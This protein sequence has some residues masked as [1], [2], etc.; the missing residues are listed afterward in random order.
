ML[1]MPCKVL[2]FTL[3]ISFLNADMKLK[4]RDQINI[5]I[6]LISIDND[7]DSCALDRLNRKLMASSQ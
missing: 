2:Y 4:D 5:N 6:K 1:Q 3:T 7:L